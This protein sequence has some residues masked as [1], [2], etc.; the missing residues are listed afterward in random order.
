VVG[1]IRLMMFIFMLAAM[2]RPSFSQPYL[3][4]IAAVLNYNMHISSPL[5]TSRAY[6][7]TQHDTTHHHYHTI[8][9]ID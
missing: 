5:L 2:S 3:L 1:D 6:I 4:S 7:Y 8:V 9:E